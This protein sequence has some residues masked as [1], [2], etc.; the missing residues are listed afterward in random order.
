[1]RRLVATGA[2]FLL[3]LL[4]ATASLPAGATDAD[5]DFAVAYQINQAHTGFQNDPVLSPPLSLRWSH[6]FSS[7]ISY[8]VIAAGKVF[9]TVRNVS[10]YGTTLYALDRA[11]GA[12]SWSRPIPGTYY[13]SNAAFEGGRVFVVNFDGVLQAFSARDGSTIWTRQLPG[14]YAFSSPPVA[15]NG[16]VYTGGAGSGGTVYAVSAATGQVRWTR[17]VAN[18]DNS[19]PAL[20]EIALFVSYAGPQVYSFNRSTGAQ[21]W[22]YNSGSSGGGGKTPVL[23]PRGLLFTRDYSSSL[24]FNSKTGAIVDTFGSVTAPAFSGNIGLFR[25]NGVL[26]ARTVVGG[27]L[28]WSFAGDGSLT[29]APIIVRSDSGEHAYVGAGSGMLYA[30]NLADGSVAWSTNV[31]SSI[32][33]PDEQ[34]VS[35]PLTGLAAGQG[36]LVVPAGNVLRAYGD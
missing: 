17:S 36:L 7:S 15:S 10:Q 6:S 32:P 8:P 11:T 34:N 20:S 35:Q 16:V 4:A 13:W 9:V 23:A 24:V 1:M 19:S 30:L 29:S 33:G 12:I 31:G 25:Y 21:I 22:H 14:Q 3:A 18:G 2:F 5:T 28:L 27:T 26:E